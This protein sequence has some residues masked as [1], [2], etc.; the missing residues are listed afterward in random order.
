MLIYVFSARKAIDLQGRQLST[1]SRARFDGFNQT[2]NRYGKDK[3]AAYNALAKDYSD[4][5]FF[6]YVYGRQGTKR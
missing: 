4:S 1:E 6:Y 3:R 5:Y 2:L